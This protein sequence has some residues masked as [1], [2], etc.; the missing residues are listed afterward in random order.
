MDL[1]NE[2]F[3]IYKTASAGFIIKN[4]YFYENIPLK[5]FQ[6]AVKSYAQALTEDEIVICLFDETVFGSAK[7]GFILTDKRLYARTINGVGSAAVENIFE[8]VCVHQKSYSEISIKAGFDAFTI[9][10]SQVLGEDTREAF[11]QIIDKIIF[12]LKDKNKGETA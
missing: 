2:I 11:Y 7:Q 3:E 9:S 10:V 6:N 12:F 1:K 5:K 8:M 4:L